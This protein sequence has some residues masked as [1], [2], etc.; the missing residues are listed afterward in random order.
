MTSRCRSKHVEKAGEEFKCSVL[1]VTHK[2]CGIRRRKPGQKWTKWW[3]KEVES[4][5]RRKKMSHKMLLQH[6]TPERKEEYRKAK[7]EAKRVV[8]KAKN[9]GSG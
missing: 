3:N 8:R 4:A 1:E 7:V 9:E 6:Y 2:V 5:I